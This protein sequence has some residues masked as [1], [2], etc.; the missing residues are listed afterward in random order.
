MRSFYRNLLISIIFCTMLSVSVPVFAATSA[1]AVNVDNKAIAVQA[2]YINNLVFL[3][4]R[5]MADLF[6]ADLTYNADDKELTIKSGKTKAVLNIG[7]STILVNGKKVSLDAAPMISENTTLIP[8]KAV[9]AI[10]G[11]S[12]AFFIFFANF[13]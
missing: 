9:T 13:I 7:S 3:P 6:G 8:V 10:W 4:A 1:L 12:Y 11:A 5:D 2:A